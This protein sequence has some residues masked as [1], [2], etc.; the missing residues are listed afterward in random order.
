MRKHPWRSPDGKDRRKAERCFC[1]AAT[2]CEILDPEANCFLPAAVWNI[3]RGG[4][5]LLLRPRFELGRVLTIELEN[6]VREFFCRLDL[7]VKYSGICFPNGA[8]LHGCAF[9][10]PLQEEELAALV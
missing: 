8:W 7:E 5:C 3:S 6:K 4:I 9:R 2:S 1:D 10:R